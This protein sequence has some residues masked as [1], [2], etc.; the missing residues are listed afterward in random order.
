MGA[1][2]ERKALDRLALAYRRMT[3]PGERVPP[4]VQLPAGETGAQES[5]QPAHSPPQPRQPPSP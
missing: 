5:S 2:E 3:R 4:L 1:I